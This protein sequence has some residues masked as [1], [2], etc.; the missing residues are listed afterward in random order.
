MLHSR[1]ILFG[2]KKDFS[3]FLNFLYVFSIVE[4]KIASSVIPKRIVFFEIS[5]LSYKDSREFPSCCLSVEKRI[6]NSMINPFWFQKRIDFF[7]ISQF[8]YKDSREFSF[9]C[10]IVEKRIA[11]SG[12]F[13]FRRFIGNA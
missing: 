8:S 11:N 5:H 10:L 3:T 12:G 1:S 7:E 13:N 9:C 6:A 2:P 4:K